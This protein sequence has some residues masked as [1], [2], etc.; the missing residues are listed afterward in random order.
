MAVGAQREPDRSEAK[1]ETGRTREEAEEDDQVAEG[2]F[3]GL[4]GV[5][6]LR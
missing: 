6:E 5:T 1:A 3:R 4:A 2:V